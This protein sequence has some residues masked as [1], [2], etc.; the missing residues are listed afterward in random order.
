MSLVVKP[1]TGGGASAFDCVPHVLRR[2]L[3]MQ[4]RHFGGALRPRLILELLGL[5]VMDFSF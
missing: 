4:A 1:A 3:K 2:E 5:V